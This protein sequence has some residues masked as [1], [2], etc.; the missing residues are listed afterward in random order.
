MVDEQLLTIFGPYQRYLSYAAGGVFLFSL[1]F[2]MTDIG[3]VL[4]YT[5]FQLG[6]KRGSGK[7]VIPGTLADTRNARYTYATHVGVEYRK[8]YGPIYRTFSGG[9][10]EIVL[11]DPADIKTYYAGDM[12]LHDKAENLGLEDYA[13]KI[14]GES[15]GG[16]SGDEWR[17]MRACLDP[18]FNI[19]KSQELVP[20]IVSRSAEWLQM[21]PGLPAT[22]LQEKNGA[23]VVDTTK[24]AFEI[25]PKIVAHRFFGELLDDELTSKLVVMTEIHDRFIA[26]IFLGFWHHF[27]IYKYLPIEANREIDKFAKDWKEL[28]V[29]K[30]E[31][32]YKRGI[33]TVASDLYVDVKEGRWTFDEFAHTIDNILFAN[34]DVSPAAIS[35]MLVELALNPAVQTRLYEDIKAAS[36][37]ESLGDTP[38]ERRETYVRK[39][40]NLL[41]YCYL[42]SARLR[43]IF[44][45]S[46]SGITHDAKVM[47]GYYIP[48]RSTIVI[49]GYTLN[50]TA[51][52]WGD[53][54]TVFRPERFATI[55]PTQYRYSLWRFGIGPRKCIAQH[56]ADKMTKAAVAEVLEH[57]EVT[58]KDNYV[59]H[60]P[61]MFVYA[62]KGTLI[63][64]PRDGRKV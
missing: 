58:L 1:Q 59:T 18:H 11:S 34:L 51:P 22:Q 12:K 35:W 50:R 21:L 30:C 28:L 6:W 39:F 9:I 41:N 47:S 46:F 55:T 52:I 16:K 44:C 60:N 24:L 17:R 13:H 40:D 64:T 27:R 61:A 19:E 5:A 54:P 3:R 20:L 2:V 42:E 43:P 56:F 36:N 14:I 49:D 31:E 33:R 32:A 23:L 57:Y 48:P 62:P 4:Q 15:V 63:L 29:G 8:K 25:P 7:G 10:P 45:Y 37:D 26:R 38:T 53:D